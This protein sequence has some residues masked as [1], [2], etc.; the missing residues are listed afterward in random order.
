MDLLP[1]WSRSAWREDAAQIVMRE[2]DTGKR[3]L[4]MY[5]TVRI[6]QRVKTFWSVGR[7]S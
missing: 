3:S 1:R 2:S 4:W 6:Q 5:A 7:Q